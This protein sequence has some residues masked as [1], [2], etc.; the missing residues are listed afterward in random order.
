MR[1]CGSEQH[2]G[3]PPPSNRRDLHPCTRLEAPAPGRLLQKSVAVNEPSLA[4][5]TSTAIQTS[6]TAKRPISEQWLAPYAQMYPS[7]YTWPQ[8]SRSRRLLSFIS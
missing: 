7:Q 3:N 6:E 4:E 5:K 1:N 2:G 8:S